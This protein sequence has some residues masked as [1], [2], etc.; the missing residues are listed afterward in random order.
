MTSSSSEGKGNDLKY[1]MRSNEKEKEG[2]NDLE[3][4]SLKATET[5]IGDSETQLTSS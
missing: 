4:G 1:E 2:K 3:S 5:E